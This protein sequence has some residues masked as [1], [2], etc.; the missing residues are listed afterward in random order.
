MPYRNYPPV[1]VAIT[2]EGFRIAFRDTTGRHRPR[3]PGAR[4]AEAHVAPAGSGTA[5]DVTDIV[6]PGWVRS[7]LVYL[8][9]ILGALIAFVGHRYGLWVLGQEAHFFLGA[10]ALSGWIVPLGS[11]L[12]IAGERRRGDL[13]RIVATAVEARV[14]A[15]ER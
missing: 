8:G 14:V 5:V 1:W 12:Q 2:A 11:W 10:L 3:R 4:V 15:E 6:A 13:A 7:V 9:I